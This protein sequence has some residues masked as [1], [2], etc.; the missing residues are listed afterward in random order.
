MHALFGRLR[1]GGAHDVV[2]KFPQVIVNSVFDDVAQATISKAININNSRLETLRKDPTTVVL[3]V[4][5]HP[6]K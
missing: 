6:I 3:F 2:H 1:G 4:H 5:R